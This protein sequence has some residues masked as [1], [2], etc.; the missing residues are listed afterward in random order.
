MKAE[1]VRLDRRWDKIQALIDPRRN[2]R[3]KTA[4]HRFA[5]HVRDQTGASIRSSAGEDLLTYGQAVF[6]RI[7]GA[8]RV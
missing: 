7:G 4:L 1:A 2:A 5:D 3:L 8:G 6:L